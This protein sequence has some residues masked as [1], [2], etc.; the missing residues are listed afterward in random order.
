MYDREYL[1][2]KYEKGEEIGSWKGRTVYVASGCDIYLWNTD[3]NYYVIYDDE[4]YEDGKTVRPIVKKNRLWGLMDNMGRIKEFN[5]GPVYCGEEKT[6]EEEEKK[7]SVPEVEVTIPEVE[8]EG[9]NPDDFLKRIEREINE[10]LKN[11]KY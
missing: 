3:K 7:V 5:A 9:E 10:T 1:R 2:K 8:V 6:E 11:F 4:R